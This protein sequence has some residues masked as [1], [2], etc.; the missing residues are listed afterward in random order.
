MKKVNVKHCYGSRLWSKVTSL[1]IF[2]SIQY[3]HPGKIESDVAS[4]NNANVHYSVQAIISNLAAIKCALILVHFQNIQKWLI[5][6][7]VL[8]NITHHQLT[9]RN[10]KHGQTVTNIA[11]I[12]LSIIK[13]GWANIILAHTSL[14]V[15]FIEISF[16][17]NYILMGPINNCYHSL[18]DILDNLLGLTKVFWINATLGI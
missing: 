17:P 6:D 13:G 3:S 8:V 1:N 2:A 15:L 16:T 14:S 11:T 9:F 12:F 5:V 7:P 18:V 10:I 4:L